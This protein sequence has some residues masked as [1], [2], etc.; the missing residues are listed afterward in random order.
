LRAAMD[1]LLGGAGMGDGRRDPDNLRVGDPLDFW[2]VEEVTRG[3]RLCLKAMMKVLGEAYLLFETVP[4]RAGKTRLRS[5]ALFRP[6]GLMGR[7][8]WWRC[9]RSINSSSAA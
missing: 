2:R 1:R 6:R 7:I 8:Y 4:V 3:K 5:G 9:C